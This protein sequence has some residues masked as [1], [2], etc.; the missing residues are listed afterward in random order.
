MLPTAK[1]T[2]SASRLRETVAVKARSHGLGANA[3]AICAWTLVSVP[4]GALLHPPRGL[5]RGRA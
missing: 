5:G 3:F 4:V 1:A 2:S